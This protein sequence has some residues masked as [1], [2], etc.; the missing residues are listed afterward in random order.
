MA[1]T[2]RDHGVPIIFMNYPVPYEVVNDTIRRTADALHVPVVDAVYDVARAPRRGARAVDAPHLR[3]RP[4]P[5]R[6]PLPLR[7]RVG[8]ADGRRAPAD[9]RESQRADG[10]SHRGLICFPAAAVLPAPRPDR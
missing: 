3:R 2:A 10:S 8:A 5:D 4:A 7:R 6:P 9:G 1:A